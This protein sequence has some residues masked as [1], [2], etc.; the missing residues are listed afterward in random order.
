MGERTQDW[1]TAR[2]ARAVHVATAAVLLAFV[3]LFATAQLVG[4]LALAPLVLAAVALA[5]TVV[6]WRRTDP[7]NPSYGVVAVVLAAGL[8]AS[9]VYLMA[10]PD[11]GADIPLGGVGAMVVCLGG[12]GFAG[13]LTR[14]R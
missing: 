3:V 2:P 6:V 11:D 10:L 1:S 14:D 13:F 12:V 8:V 9:I 4:P 7:P 5:V